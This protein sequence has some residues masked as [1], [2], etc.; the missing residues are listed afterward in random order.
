MKQPHPFPLSFAFVRRAA[1]PLFGLAVPLSLTM[2]CA[3]EM[4][5][6]YPLCDAM[7]A[8]ACGNIGQA[9]RPQPNEPTGSTGSPARSP[10]GSPRRMLDIHTDSGQLV[11]AIA[12][13]GT[14]V[15][16]AAFTVGATA[17]S[18]AFVSAWDDPAA[19][20]TPSVTPSVTPIVEA[21]PRTARP[22]VE[23]AAVRTP[24]PPVRPTWGTEDSEACE[25]DRRARP[26]VDDACRPA[27]GNVMTKG[28]CRV[29][30]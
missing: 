5:A 6:S 9:G 13:V 16:L 23:V 8:P 1:R 12:T 10:A 30:R 25:A 2:A 21:P 20:F 17:A 4:G 28:G 14:T 7:G 24:A 15:T 22:L 27:C 29:R 18:V 3:S 26:L 19:T 11:S